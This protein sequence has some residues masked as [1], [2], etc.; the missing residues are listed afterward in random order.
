MLFIAREDIWQYPN[1][2]YISNFQEEGTWMNW[3]SWVI[4]DMYA[5]KTASIINIIYKY[6]AAAC[7]RAKMYP[8]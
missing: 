8:A 3:Y 7:A 2:E 5:R 1:R 4:K 6:S